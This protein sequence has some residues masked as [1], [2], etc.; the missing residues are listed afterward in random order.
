MKTASV[1]AFRGNKSKDWWLDH[2][3]EKYSTAGMTPSEFTFLN[4]Q[5][6]KAW[7]DA[8]DAIMAEIQD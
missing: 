1:T 5:A 6:T 3:K 8:K 2:I 4:T 7:T